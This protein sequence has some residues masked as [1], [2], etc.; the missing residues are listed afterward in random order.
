MNE[1]SRWIRLPLINMTMQTSDLA[2]LALFMYLARLISKKQDMIK[3]FKKGY[4]PLIIPVG[5]TCVLIAPAN[6]STAMLLGASCLLL[7]FIGRARIKHILVTIGIALIPV[8]FLI[9]AAVIHH[10]SGEDRKSIQNK[11]LLP[12]FLEE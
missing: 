1:G 12:A 6:L 4:L 10:K 5:I 11:K 9:A 2:K 7:L 8:I 3:D